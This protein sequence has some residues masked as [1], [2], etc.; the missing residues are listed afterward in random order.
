MEKVYFFGF[1]AMK[2]GNVIANITEEL[3][4]FIHPLRWRQQV[5][6]DQYFYQATVS[7]TR[8]H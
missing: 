3:A 6:A 5:S 4:A 1:D 7:Q 8:R 2:T